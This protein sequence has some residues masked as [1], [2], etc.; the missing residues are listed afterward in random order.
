MASEY[1]IAIAIPAAAAI[2]A[3]ILGAAAAWLRR[4]GTPE[5]NYWSLRIRGYDDCK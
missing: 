5:K 4:K 2:P 3:L 1:W